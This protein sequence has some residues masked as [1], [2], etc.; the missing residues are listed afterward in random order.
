MISVAKLQL[1]QPEIMAVGQSCT[2]KEEWPDTTTVDKILRW[3]E[4]RNVS[5]MRGFL[6]MAGTVRNWIKSFTEICNPLTKLTWVMKTKFEWDK[7]QWVA[8]EEVKAKVAMCE[9][10]QPIDHTLPYNVILSI[11]T[12]VIAIGYVL[13]QLNSTKWRQPTWFGL[14]IWNKQISC[15]S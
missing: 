15:Y 10:I 4:C 2:Y 1:C 8:M 7:E 6:E 3:P 14:I 12:S 9:I 5:E 13:A 11:N